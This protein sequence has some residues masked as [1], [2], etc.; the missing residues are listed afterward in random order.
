M[1]EVAHLPYTSYAVAGR[2]YRLGVGV[3][4]QVVDVERLLADHAPELVELAGGGN[5]DRLLSAGHQAWAPVRTVL[6][7]VISETIGWPG[8]AVSV[9][10]VRLRLP[11]T[12]G[13]YVDFYG[14]EHHASN[15]GALLRP[16]QPPLPASWKH[17][18]I[19]YHGRAG[20]I[21]TS[22][23]V[24]RRPKGMRPEPDG[25]PSF[26][27]SR[28]LDIEAELGFV[29]G[30]SA[31]LGEVPLSRAAEHLFG[32]TLTNDWSAR[33][34]Q[35]F[36]YVP[37][38]PH[39]GKSFLTTI[40]PWITPLAALDQARIVPPERDVPL[41]AYLDDTDAEPWGLAIDIEVLVNGEV[42]SRPPVRTMYWTAAQML[43]HLTVNGASLRPGDFFASGT[44]SGLEPGQRGSLLE[45]S[46]GGKEPVR[47]ADGS[48]LSFLRDDDEVVLRA[49]APGPDGSVI[50]LG[51]C[52]GQVVPAD[53]VT[54]S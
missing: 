35:A 2:P 33:D 8:Y 43:A 18:P 40:S 17:I 41:A 7:Q 46:W 32:V 1:T 20:T 13:D 29:L 5:L 12:V 45:L 30:G 52:T 50:R 15:V 14:N 39:L 10:D 22:G 16:G 42:V 28:R 53:V 25:P 27:P 26:G 36:E 34:I 48:E 11:F 24:V 4:D 31:P 21:R 23:T 51:E 6:Q 37:L 9:A 19:G 3:D 38:G 47:L 44:V 54:P 49:T